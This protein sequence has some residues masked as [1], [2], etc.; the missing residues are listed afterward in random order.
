MQAANDKGLPG[1]FGAWAGLVYDGF[2]AGL[3]GGFQVTGAG[4][5]DVF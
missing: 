4:G 3:L 1:T 5:L 2:Y